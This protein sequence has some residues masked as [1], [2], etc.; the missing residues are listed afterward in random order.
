M[1]AILKTFLIFSLF[2]SL[3]YS[4]AKSKKITFHS[5]KYDVFLQM[6]EMN[7]DVV[8][9]C[10]NKNFEEAYIINISGAEDYYFG[11][12]YYNQRYIIK[13][14]LY[15]YKEEQLIGTL[16]TPI[17]LENTELIS[18]ADRDKCYNTES[19]YFHVNLNGRLTITPAPEINFFSA[20]NNYRCKY[21]RHGTGSVF[22]GR[23]NAQDLYF[24]IVDNEFS[25]IISFASSKVIIFSLLLKVISE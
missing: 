9:G 7:V 2:F 6:K 17:N 18:D 5:K 1:G 13:D 11:G 16:N 14:D 15:V 20:I 23:K 10:Q 8:V 4:Y 21:D 25:L 24:F 22:M 12:Y 19:H 3:N